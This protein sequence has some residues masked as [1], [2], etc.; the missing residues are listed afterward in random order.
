MTLPINVELVPG[1][2]AGAVDVELLKGGLRQ[3][4]FS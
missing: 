4:Y 3:V 1:S 2:A